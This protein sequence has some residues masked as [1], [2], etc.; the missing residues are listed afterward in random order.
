MSIF[1][2]ISLQ[3]YSA[4]LGGISTLVGTG[5]NLAMVKLLKILYQ[6][7]PGVSFG[8]WMVFAVPLTIVS[9]G[10]MWL[11]FVFV[12]IGWK[13]LRFFF[14]SENAEFSHVLRCVTFDI[15]DYR[16]RKAELGSLCFEE[17]VVLSCLCLM[18]VLWLTRTMF[19]PLV[20]GWSALLFE[21]L[22]GEKR[23]RKEGNLTFLFQE[24]ELLRFC[25][26][27]LFL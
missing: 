13:P 27:F 16:R 2:L 1:S 23:L 17:I 24:M 8:L 20:P 10:F 21:G 7:F 22:V 6:D 19:P 26:V 11:F 15:E 18:A 14:F 25:F 3:A 5:P 12:V 4:S 9:I